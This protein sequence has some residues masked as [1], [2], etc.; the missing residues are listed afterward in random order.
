MFEMWLA[1]RDY[2]EQRVAAFKTQGQV[3]HPRGAALW[4]DH[5]EGFIMKF[6]QDCA[7]YKKGICKGEIEDLGCADFTV[8][9]E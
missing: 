8:M 1:G 9:G 2:D 5:F 7:R 6:C 4:P 3:Q